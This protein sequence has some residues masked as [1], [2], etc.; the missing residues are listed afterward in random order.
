M[1]QGGADTVDS[2]SPAPS[3]P[4]IDATLRSVWE[5]ALKQRAFNVDGPR[6]TSYTD[7]A[8]TFP[9]TH[10]CISGRFRKVMYLVEAR[11]QKVVRY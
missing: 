9:S 10:A 6:H 8:E 11:C 3:V 5:R 2:R 4:E 1:V 7:S